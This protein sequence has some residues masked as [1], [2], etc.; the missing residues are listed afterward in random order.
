M[1]VDFKNRK[2]L[3]IIV[4]NGLELLFSAE[5][6]K[7]TTIMNKIYIGENG[8]NCDGSMAG[9]STFTHILDSAKPLKDEGLSFY[10]MVT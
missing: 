1:D 3:N 5:D 10:E 9:Y 6:P 7:S 4:E 8:I 2:L